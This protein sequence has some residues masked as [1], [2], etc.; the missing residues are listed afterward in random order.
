M[1]IDIYFFE[2]SIDIAFFVPDNLVLSYLN[3]LHYITHENIW[4]LYFRPPRSYLGLLS[5]E[6]KIMA[7]NGLLEWERRNEKHKKDKGKI[8]VM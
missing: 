1:E 7:S 8:K 6:T 2:P 5:C 4:R 3:E